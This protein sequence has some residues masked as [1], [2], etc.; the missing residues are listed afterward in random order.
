M[1][2]AVN[3]IRVAAHDAASHSLLGLDLFVEAWRRN[4]TSTLHAAIFLNVLRL[5]IHVALVNERP[6]SQAS[7]NCCVLEGIFSDADDPRLVNS[8]ITTLVVSAIGA[9]YD[10]DPKSSERWSRLDNDSNEWKRPY[11][12]L[13]YPRSK[14]N[15]ANINPVGLYCLLTM[16]TV[17]PISLKTLNSLHVLT[18]PPSRLPPIL[19]PLPPPPDQQHSTRHNPATEPLRHQRKPTKH[20]PPSQQTQ[21]YTPSTRSNPCPSS[22]ASAPSPNPTQAPRA[23]C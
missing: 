6:L 23:S 12:R 20:P 11:Q 19:L 3:I 10:G 5:Y 18:V 4:P 9:C 8:R 21:T 13:S 16:F 22:A 15:R 1:L 17:R 14:A 7:I 2:A